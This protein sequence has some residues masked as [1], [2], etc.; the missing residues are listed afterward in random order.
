MS[1]LIRVFIGYDPHETVAYHVLAHSIEAR[2]SQ[3]VSITPLALTQLKRVFTRERNPLQSTD[4]AFSRFLVPY[5]CDYEGWAI[6][7]DCDMLV[8]DDMAK[9]WNLRDDKYAVMCVQHDY[10]PKTGEKF[11]GQVQTAYE[12][13]NWSSVML[14]NCA[15][16]KALTPEYVNTATGLEL[17][18]F[19]WLADESL[20]GA[21]PMRWNFLVGEYSAIP[22]EQV[23]NLHYTLGGPY[24][25]DYKDCDYADLWTTEK[26]AMLFANKDLRLSRAAPAPEAPVAS[27]LSPDEQF[28]Q[29]LAAYEHG[30]RQEAETFARELV[31][32][33]PYHV[34]GVN[35]MAVICHGAGRLPEASDWAQQAVQLVP[36]NPH[37]HFNLATL[38]LASGDRARAKTA[39]DR[40]LQLQPTYVQAF[41]QRVGMALEEEDFAGAEKLLNNLRVHFPDTP[42]L[43][44]LLS[45]VL[46]KQKKFQDVLPV[47]EKLLALNPQQS[48]EFYSAFAVTLQRNGRLAESA[49]M[50]KRAFDAGYADAEAYYNYANTLDYLARHAE[51]KQAYEKALQLDPGFTRAR[52]GLMMLEMKLSNLTLGVDRYHERFIVAER[53]ERIYPL[54]RWKGESLKGKRLLIWAEQG[55]GDVLMFAGFLPHVLELTRACT[56]EM[57]PY[58]IALL[59]RS[60]P[61]A[62]FVPMTEEANAGLIAEG[63]DY[64]CG[65]GDLMQY[66]LKDYK[67]AAHKPY[68]VADAQKVKELKARYASLGAGKLVGISWHT[69]NNQ[70]GLLRNIPLEK[71]LPILKKPGYRFISLQYMD[72]RDEIEAFNCAHGTAIHLDESVDPV[73]DKDA[74]AA[75]VASLDAVI[76]VQ[77]STVHMA[78]ALGVPATLMLSQASDWR[79]GIS[80]ENVWYESV[81]IV[82]Q[83]QYGEWDDV[84]AQVAKGF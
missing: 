69:I 15:K 14:I 59:A 49:N 48:A 56:V 82:R 42:Q 3:P 19:R 29:A 81:K 51:S 58:M 83:Q 12:K 28:K 54:P 30:R 23:S 6:F 47:Y 34:D 79:W 66:L 31:T 40:T 16:C 65:L 41:Q 32:Q 84:I 43:L 52:S 17:H 2:A 7:M 73:A 25:P 62:R 36:D 63:Y 53:K 55:I 46:L 60:F 76:S 75:Q 26:E 78:G 64:Y 9:L 80:G 44:T 72:Y 10:S 70:T 1:Q 39:L 67:P 21:L 13:K 71:W 50:H 22:A 24:F 45:T 5:L 35:L 74:F 4:F 8:L 57:Y 11:L 77:N 68:A 37:F 27:R 33:H 18:R 61:K 20:I 38:S